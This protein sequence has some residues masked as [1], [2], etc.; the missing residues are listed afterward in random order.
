MPLMKLEAAAILHEVG[1]EKH[2]ASY[3]LIRKLEPP[4][5]WSREDLHMV[6]AIVRFHCGALPCANH[7]GL[8]ELSPE[9]RRLSRILAGILRLAHAFDDTHDGHVQRL[10]V[11]DKSAFLLVSASGYLPLSATGQHVAE[12]RYLL[13][14][15]LRKPIVIRPL[16]L[17]SDRPMRRGAQASK[18]REGPRRR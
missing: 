17:A 12:A 11:E 5:G 14:T 16:A 6:A 8:R 1:G 13:E 3:R 15:V 7:G 9:Q 2:K 10:Q 18:R 4:L